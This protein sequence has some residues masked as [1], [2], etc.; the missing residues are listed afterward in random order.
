M[1][2]LKKADVKLELV[3]CKPGY[4]F[5]TADDEYILSDGLWKKIEDDIRVNNISSYRKIRR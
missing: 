4:L 5:W 1:E 2:I 3:L